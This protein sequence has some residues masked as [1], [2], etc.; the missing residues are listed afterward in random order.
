MVKPSCEGYITFGGNKWEFEFNVE[1]KE[2][3]WYGRRARDKW[4]RGKIYIGKIVTIDF[5]KM[6]FL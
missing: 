4:I 5:H 3:I 1:D 6:F 2:I